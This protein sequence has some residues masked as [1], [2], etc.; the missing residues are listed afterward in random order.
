[1]SPAPQHMAAVDRASLFGRLV[2]CMDTSHCF[3]DSHTTMVAAERDVQLK[4]ADER[5]SSEVSAAEDRGSTTAA[6]VGVGMLF[7]GAFIGAAVYHRVWK[8][9][10]LRAGGPHARI[11]A[12]LPLASSGISDAIHAAGSGDVT[13]VARDAV[14]RPASRSTTDAEDGSKIVVAKGGAEQMVL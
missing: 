6:G 9:R 10:L 5:V 11:G 7:L 4:S 2:T 3:D 14:H 12:S 13:V 8:A 1:M